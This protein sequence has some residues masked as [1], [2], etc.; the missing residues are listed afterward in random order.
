MKSLS[1]GAQVVSMPAL[2][3]RLF[4]S[5][6]P[7]PCCLSHAAAAAPAAAAVT[8]RGGQ[9]V[10]VS[11]QVPSSSRYPITYYGSAVIAPGVIDVHVHMNEPGREDWE[12]EQCL[13]TSSPQC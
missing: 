7:D 2:K 9:I 3:A 11:D 5:C 1:A 10:S 4:P 6:V 8:I 12:G 13:V